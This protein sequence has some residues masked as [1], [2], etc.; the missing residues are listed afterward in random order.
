MSKKLRIT[1]IRSKIG[2][3]KNQKNTLKAL[4]LHKIGQFKD[5]DDCPEIRGMIKTVNHLVKWEEIDA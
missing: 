4:G 2:H 3:L 1:Q 5:H